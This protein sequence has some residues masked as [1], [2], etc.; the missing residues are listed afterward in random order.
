MIKRILKELREHAPFTL[1]GAFTGILIMTVSYGI[2]EGVAYK[3]FYVF[4]PMHVVLS[5]LV[6]AAFYRNYKADKCNIFALL[7]I[8]LTGSVGIATISDSII[9][10]IGER[11]LNMP[12]AEAHIGFI[13]E[14]KI[15]IPLALAGTVTAYFW[16]RTKFPHA[17]HVLISTWASLFHVLMAKGSPLGLAASAAVFLFLF[18]AV[19]APCCIS[20]IVYPLLF[21]GKDAG[22]YR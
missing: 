10:Y 9:P 13:E 17:G 5:A 18:I 8:G 16:P 4:H 7:I 19:W 2:P 21:V 12:H 11:L 22:K 1:F 6:T 3:L 14:W 15:V 20:D